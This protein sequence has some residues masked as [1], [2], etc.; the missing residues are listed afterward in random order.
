MHILLL[1]CVS[2]VYH[3]EVKDDFSTERSALA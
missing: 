2:S 1:E 3:G